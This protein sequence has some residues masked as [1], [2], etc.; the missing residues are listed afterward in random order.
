M[1]TKK[2]GKEQTIYVKEN[3]RVNENIPPN[4]SNNEDTLIAPN[5]LLHNY[6]TNRN[7][8]IGKS[9]S[10]TMGEFE[11]ENQ[12]LKL[13]LLELEKANNLLIGKLND[14]GTDSSSSQRKEYICRPPLMQNLHIPTGTQYIYIYIY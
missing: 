1:T 7:G 2:S 3:Y 9:N 12:L 13:K 4:Y 14:Q 5:I 8:N 6:S 10:K 11:N